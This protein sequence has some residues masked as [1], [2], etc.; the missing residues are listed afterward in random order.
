MINP[1]KIVEQF[2]NEV[3]EYA[4]APYAVATDCCSHAIFLSAVYNRQRHKISNAVIPANTYLSVPMQL[5]HAG[6]Q[7]SFSKIDWSGSYKIGGTNIVDSAARFTTGMYEPGTYYCVSFQF[8]KILSTIK[9]G[10]ILTDDQDFFHWASHAV[11]D[12]RDMNND[13]QAS[14]VNILGYHM[15]MTPETAQMGLNNL[16][17]LPEQ[18]KDIAGSNT[19]PDISYLRKVLDE[20][21]EN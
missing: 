19:Y 3:A 2:E 14:P 12:G 18:N 4:G 20:N 11:H 7:V 10:M 8:H 21:K 1:F 17:N 15:F 5:H 9:G 16:A 6:Y 13:W